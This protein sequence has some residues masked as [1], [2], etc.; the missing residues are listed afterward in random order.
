MN[1]AIRV[2]LTSYSKDLNRC[3]HH[4]LYAAWVPEAFSDL[5]AGRQ[6]SL[7]FGNFNLKYFE[8]G[9]LVLDTT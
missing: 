1:C 5:I 6:R 3:G 7:R 2:C 8:N 9:P 4:Q